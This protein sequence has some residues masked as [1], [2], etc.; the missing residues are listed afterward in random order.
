[1]AGG[2]SHKTPI[3]MSSWEPTWIDAKFPLLCVHFVCSL[4]PCPRFNAIPTLVLLLNLYLSCRNIRV[5][6]SII[7]YV[8]N[9]NLIRADTVMGR[10]EVNVAD[11]QEGVRP[12]IFCVKVL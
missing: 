4:S 5:T 7:F 6:S 1:M 8:K 12:L 3:C 11:L 10:A 9:K 2:I